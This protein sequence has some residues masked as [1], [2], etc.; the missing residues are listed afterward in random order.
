MFICTSYKSIWKRHEANSPWALVHFYLVKIFPITNWP[1]QVIATNRCCTYCQS[2]YGLMGQKFLVIYFIYIDMY[3]VW[4]SIIKIKLQI[5]LCICLYLFKFHNLSIVLSASICRKKGSVVSSLLF[6]CKQIIH[7][8]LPY[9][10]MNQLSGNFRRW[11]LELE[12]NDYARTQ[13]I[14][15]NSTNI[16]Y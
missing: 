14:T 4:K 2:L 3:N 11:I 6:I 9:R 5:Y 10:K 16:H 7:H 1:V 8:S 15:F 12:D 13:R